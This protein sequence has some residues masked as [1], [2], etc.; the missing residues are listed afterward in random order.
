MN[1]ATPRSILIV[2]SRQYSGNLS[3]FAIKHPQ[4]CPS[5]LTGVLTIPCETWHMSIGS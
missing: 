4:S 3:K 5:L 1:S 2:L